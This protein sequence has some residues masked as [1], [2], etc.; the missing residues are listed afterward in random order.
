VSRVLT[1]RHVALIAGGAFALTLGANAV[2]TVAAVQSFSGLVATDSYRASQ[3]FDRARAAQEALGWRLSLGHGEGVLTLA[4]TD[5]GGAPVRPA[6]LAVAVGR[7]TTP[8]EDRALALE[9]TPGGYAAVAPLAPG[10]WRLE[11]EATAADGT[12]FRQRRS[13]YVPPAR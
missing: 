10:D 9:P 8:R 4:L 12:A 1:G 13:L 2:L 3:D 6:A 5:A 11:I 7:P